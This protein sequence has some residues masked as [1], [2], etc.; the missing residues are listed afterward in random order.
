MFTNIRKILGI[1]VVWIGLSAIVLFLLFMGCGAYPINLSDIQNLSPMTMTVL[2]LRALRLTCAFIVGGSLAVAGTACQAALRNPLAEPYILGV[3][4]GGSVGAAIAIILGL[5]VVSEFFIP[6][7]ALAGAIL[8]L[9]LVLAVSRR[10]S[11]D[12]P[13]GTALAG[14]VIGSMCSSLLMFIISMSNSRELNS[15]TWWLLGS[16]QPSGLALL[17][18]AGS[19]LIFATALFTLLGREI[20]AVTFG[21]ETAFSLGTDPRKLCYILLGV[22]SLLAACAVAVSGIIG[23][24]GLITPHIARSLFGARHR[25]LFPVCMLLGGIFL[26]ICDTFARSLFATTELPVGVITSFIGGPF[27][28]WLLGRRRVW[29]S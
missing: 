9:I 3:S 18:S 26:M 1:P 7:F 29:E 4:G 17:L 10:W 12:T 2:K 13:A 6:A 8:A 21:E 24:V 28:L 23:F 5:A 27:F 15:I 11:A 22:S 14:V 16:L 25:Q 20:D 19:S